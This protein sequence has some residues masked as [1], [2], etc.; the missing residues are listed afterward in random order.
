M[1][2]ALT[3]GTG[4]SLGRRHECRQCWHQD[5]NKE[6]TQ[7][8]LSQEADAGGWPQLQGQ[9]GLHRE[10]KASRP[11]VHSEILAKKKP[12]KQNQLLQAQ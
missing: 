12:P 8:P 2:P 10:L 4:S 11:E 9:S 6:Y 7:Q 5:L 1:P 3:H